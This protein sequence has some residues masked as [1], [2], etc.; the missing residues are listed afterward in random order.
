[1]D[2]VVDAGTGDHAVVAPSG[3]NARVGSQAPTGNAAA[4]AA[5]KDQ[6]NVLV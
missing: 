2:V 6:L 5:P 4:I 3:V 1:M